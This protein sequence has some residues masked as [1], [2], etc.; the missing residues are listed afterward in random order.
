LQ[1][2]SPGLFVSPGPGSPLK[3]TESVEAGSNGSDSNFRL[4][5]IRVLDFLLWLSENVNSVSQKKKQRR[6][7][8][9]NGRSISKLNRRTFATHEG[10]AL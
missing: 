4:I 6:G 5:H 8:R 1:K 9:L 3:E 10:L 7:R 2:S